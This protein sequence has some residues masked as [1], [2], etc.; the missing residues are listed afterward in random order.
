MVVMWIMLGLMAVGVVMLALGRRGRV[1][2]DHPVCRACRFDLSG[3]WPRERVCPECG[4]AL[5]LERAVVIGMRRRKRGLV[6]LGAAVLLVGVIGGG[7]IALTRASGVNWNQYMPTGWLIARIDT[8]G[9][10]SGA[11]LDELAARNG[12]SELSS[13]QVAELARRL[14]GWQGDRARAWHFGAGDLFEQLAAR[15]EVSAE[16]NDVYMRQA[17]VLSARTRPTVHPGV[18]IPF[19]LT[20]SLGRGG[21]STRMFLRY[22][23]A[24]IEV[25]GV[26]SAQPGASYGRASMHG[27]GSSTTT[28]SRWNPGLGVGSY[29]IDALWKV[30]VQDSINEGAVVLQTWDL[31]SAGVVTVVPV[32]EEIVGLRGDEAMARAMQAEMVVE[33]VRARPLK[34]GGEYVSANFRSAKRPMGIAMDLYL[35]SGER[36]WRIGAVTIPAGESNYSASVGGHVE[37]FVGAWARLELRPSVAA[38]EGTIGMDEILGEPLVY[39]AGVEWSE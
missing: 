36:E 32:E 33:R 8:A 24:R 31:A 28:T 2:N 17:V 26:E 23:L 29:K 22:E 10:G 25:D 39:E 14:L 18:G 6:A 35:V 1:V 16:Q 13:E 34:D 37:G 20:L 7:G 27:P 3:V 9:V 11:M 30:S 38:A 12:A 21:N 4:G 15:G 5:E 19:E